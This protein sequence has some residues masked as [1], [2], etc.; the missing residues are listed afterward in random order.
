MYA[1]FY[2][3]DFVL[4]FTYLRPVLYQH[5]GHDS[6]YRTPSMSLVPSHPKHQDYLSSL[7]LLEYTST[8]RVHC[9]S[10]RHQ[11]LRIEF[12]SDN[13][14]EIRL[15]FVFLLWE[16]NGYCNESLEIEWMDFSMIFVVVEKNWAKR[17]RG[18]TIRPAMP[19]LLQRLFID[20]CF[21]L[22]FCVVV[23]C[24]LGRIKE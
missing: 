24:L 18:K 23:F 12:T 15:S 11:F 22:G 6:Q 3:M 20:F 9:C 13:S 7:L 16:F 5:S 2:T 21:A 19:A 14:D 4:L 8:I 17:Q 10:K 1:R